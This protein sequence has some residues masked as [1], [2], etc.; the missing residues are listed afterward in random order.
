MLT[1]K[2]GESIVNTFS[3]KEEK[4]RGWSNK[5][6][7][8][9]PICGDK[10]LYC[11]GD[12]KIP[13]F[14]HEKNNDCL[15]IYS[16]G[17]TQEHLKGV[18]ML[19]EWLLNQKDIKNLQLEKWIPE[20]RQRPDIYFEIVENNEIKKYAI[21]FQ[22]SPIATKYNERHD[23]YRLNNII[24]IWILGFSKYD[25]NNYNSLLLE[26]DIC[27]QVIKNVKTKTIER[28]IKNSSK[29][30]MYLT[31]GKL[32]K[33]TSKLIETYD[34]YCNERKT[35]FDFIIDSK[36]ITDCNY[37]N[38][39]DVNSLYMLDDTL[40][41]KRIHKLEEYTDKLNEDIRVN[42]YKYDISIE[43]SEIELKI[44][45]I[46]NKNALIMNLNNFSEEKLFKYYNK[47]IELHR[48]K[49]DLYNDLKKSCENLNNRFSI[50]NKNC[51]FDLQECNHGDS[52]LYKIEFNSCEFSRIFYIKEKSIDCTKEDS[53]T[54]PFRGKRGGIGWKRIYYDK[55]IDR[56]EY[57]TI[58]AN[59]LIDYI[60]NTISNTLRSI[61]YGD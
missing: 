41:R 43:A 50:V 56:L 27:N 48:M 13:Y 26:Y 32:V 51:A 7:L 1:C 47:E 4:L 61:R 30:L 28:E 33:I 54:S 49:I 9:C 31:G 29:P 20:T 58:S 18:K 15:D 14:R 2:V 45:N 3:F 19:Y 24:D 17:V 42:R 37:E 10:L 57:N 8:K 21:E 38:L 6:M 16:E 46:S 60:S 39:I 52:Y 59:E 40:L 5:S 11:H 44:I 36:I 25:I 53:Y 34:N 35:I 12:Y 55:T 23:L 22:C